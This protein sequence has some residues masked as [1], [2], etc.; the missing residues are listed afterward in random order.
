MVRLSCFFIAS[1][2]ACSAWATSI[3]TLAQLQ[4]HH[5]IILVQCDSEQCQRD[6]VAQLQQAKLA[7]QERHI[8]WFVSTQA[9]IQANSSVPLGEQLHD[10]LTS[11]ELT[12]P[13]T[14]L[15]GKDGDIK[16]IDSQLK[17]QQL[18]EQI[19]QMPMRQA[20]MRW[21]RI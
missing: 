12:R 5:R 7:V 11:H 1:L 14:I 21:Q 6:S 2:F 18:F 19:D 20:E 15:I 8:V 17:L 3:S 10:A 4:W 16:A 9:G 13:Q